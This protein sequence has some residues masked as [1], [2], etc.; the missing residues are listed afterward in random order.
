MKTLDE[1][2]LETFFSKWEFKALYHLCASDAES[3]SIGE[4]LKTPQDAD[5]FMKVSLGYT[6]TYGNEELLEEISK[7][8]DK[9]SEDNLLCF[10]GAEEGIFCAMKELLTPDDHVIVITPNYQSF[11]SIPASICSVSAVSL[12][13][14]NEWDLDPEKVRSAVRENTKLLVINFPHNPTGK[15]ISKE[16]QNELINIARENGFYIFSDE[17]Y[18]L[19]ERNPDKRIPQIADVYE[20]G[21]S[22]NVLSKSYGLPGLR[23]GW[24]ATQDS[25]LLQR[26]ERM[27]LYLSICNSA[28]SEF[29]AIR[30]LRNKESILNKIRSISAT[31][32]GYLNTFFNKYQELFK[33]IEPDGGCIGFPRYLGPEGTEAFTADLLDKKGV[34]LLPPSVYYS[35][36]AGIEY[37]GFRIGFGRTNMREGLLELGKYLEEK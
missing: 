27:K 26:M 16:V 3:M 9:I 10:C 1:F 21:I 35:K 18:R 14:E 11:E 29:L 33:W 24:I 36:A 20:K 6:K 28:P 15:I 17:V 30:A 31:N 25:D 32:L 12:D 8:Y 2:K 19:I 7:T 22:L 37:D 34:L 13:S 23:I 4:L 5:D